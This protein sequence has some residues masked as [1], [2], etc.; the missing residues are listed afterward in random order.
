MQVEA[1]TVACSEAEA[2]RRVAR[3]LG[4][5]KMGVDGWC[6]ARAQKDWDL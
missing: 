3:W 6:N 4:E 2:R 5:G 1:T